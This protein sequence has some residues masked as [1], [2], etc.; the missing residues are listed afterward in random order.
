MTGHGKASPL[1]L[2]FLGAAQEVTGS[3]F[4]LRCGRSRVLV[5]C[6][7][8]QGSEAQERRN[9][10]PF[11]FDINRIDA[12]VI[13]H[14]H[15]DHSGRLPLLVR[16]G[17]KGP[18]YTH[19]ATR[20]L[21][22]IMLKDAAYLNERE[23]QWDN[24]KRER[25][26]LPPLEPL[27]TMQDAA[28]AVR[29]IRAL[30]YDAVHEVAPGVRIRLHDAGH[31]LGSAIV[32]LWA[33]EQGVE[34]KLVFSGDLGHR[35]A[36]ILRDPV[37]VD[38]AD[39]VILESTYGDR[40]H[41]S[42]EATWA[43]LGEVLEQA[44]ADG[45]NVLIPAFAVG[46]TQELLYAFRLNY[47]A[48]KLDRWRIFLDSPMAIEATDVYM[49]HLDLY[50]RDAQRVRERHGNPLRLP[51]LHL[52]RTANQS[53]GINRIRSGA[54]IIAG[55]GMCTGGRIKHHLKHNIWRSNTRV[56]FV[57]FQARGTLGR[58]LVDGAREIT[59]WGE[60]MRVA[61]SIH[62]IGGFSAHADQDG[63]LQWY[64]AIDGHPPVS[65]VHGEPQAMEALGRVMEERFHNRV[66]RPSAGTR[67]DLRSWQVAA[68]GDAGN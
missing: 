32:E 25:K 67:I 44:R 31:I 56:L 30:D 4:L 12:V 8:V 57:G 6:G 7:L 2:E 1:E 36:P 58:A 33:R 11:P 65:L 35:G 18:I 49:R 51:N 3:C 41:R 62:T 5:E 59:L 46:R 63:L 28:D 13:T 21:L 50:D 47:D 60:T 45:G 61:A 19:R 15:L 55:S 48:W 14:A 22:R 66:L 54:L 29:R 68:G 17:Y 42:W 26:G 38:S 9:R 27:Y 52:S 34:R 24:R 40:R 39:L 37:Q 43:E 10:D 23:V 53:M 20:D 64:G 16:S